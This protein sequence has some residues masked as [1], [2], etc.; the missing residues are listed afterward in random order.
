M[1][2][3][4]TPRG[5]PRGSHPER[6][7]EGAKSKDLTKKTLRFR[8]AQQGYT[9]G[10]WVVKIP[11]PLKKLPSEEP[12]GVLKDGRARIISPFVDPGKR[13]KIGDLCRVKTV[14]L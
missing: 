4:L 5:V 2:K 7:T 13:R 12:S 3:K 14:H 8:P 10:E 6:S 11:R 9:Q 1:I